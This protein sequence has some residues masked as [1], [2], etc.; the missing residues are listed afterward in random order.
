M[1]EE[2]GAMTMN[3]VNEVS[4]LQCPILACA[5]RHCFIVLPYILSPGSMFHGEGNGISTNVNPS[6][7]WMKLL[8]I[9]SPGVASLACLG[10]RNYVEE[11]GITV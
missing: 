4:L 9:A 5:A 11:G 1:A 7:G 3:L 8:P 6:M 10:M 2:I